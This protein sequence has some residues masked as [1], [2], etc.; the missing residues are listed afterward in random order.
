VYGVVRGETWALQITAEV[1]HI[2]H[3]ASRLR[4]AQSCAADQ[5]NY[6]VAPP[7]SAFETSQALSVYATSTSTFS[8]RQEKRDSHTTCC[9]FTPLVPLVP[10]VRP[11][12]W[13]VYFYSVIY[14]QYHARTFC[15]SYITLEKE[16]LRFV[17]SKLLDISLTLF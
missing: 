15:V 14:Y 6:A 12:A 13:V 2:N 17:R 11:P 16:T 8:P 1:S 9:T 10:L 4:S 5:E 7:Q 3:K